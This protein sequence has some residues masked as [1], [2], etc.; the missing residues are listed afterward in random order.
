M[1]YKN[2]CTWNFFYFF[3]YQIIYSPWTRIE[4]VMR[5]SCS[6]QTSNETANW[7]L[8]DIS[9]CSPFCVYTRR[10][11][12]L[13]FRWSSRESDAIILHALLVHSQEI[14]GICKSNIYVLFEDAADFWEK[15][16]ADQYLTRQ[17]LF[18]DQMH[19]DRWINAWKLVKHETPSVRDRY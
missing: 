3:L 16:L 9:V 15:I 8:I 1:I 17:C 19:S 18:P 7:L 12:P 11:C 13:S 5:C 2:A 10:N 4:E 14:K 6:A